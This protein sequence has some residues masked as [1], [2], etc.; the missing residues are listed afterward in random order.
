MNEFYMRI[1]G[2]EAEDFANWITL[3]FDWDDA[4]DVNLALDLMKRAIN[5]GHSV[6]FSKEN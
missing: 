6:I 4:A 2:P 5:E 1:E 3:K